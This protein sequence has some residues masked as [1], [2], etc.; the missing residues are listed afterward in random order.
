[1]VLLV[2]SFMACKKS[3]Q[4][5]GPDYI[6]IL[7]DDAS[8]KHYVA[9][10][11]LNSTR[12]KLQTASSLN[13]NLHRELISELNMAK[14]EVSLSLILN[15]YNLRLDAF[16][17]YLEYRIESHIKMRKNFPELNQ[18]QGDSESE[19]Y[20][21]AYKSVANNFLQKVKL[22]AENVS[23]ITN[24]L[25]VKNV[26]NQPNSQIQ[27]QSISNS[28]LTV[29]NEA[30]VMQE[31]ELN[32]DQMV[33][34]M[35]NIIVDHIQSTDITF[36]EFFLCLH[37]AAIGT[38]GEIK[39]IFDAAQAASTAAVIQEM[40]AVGAKWILKNI[41]WIGAAIL[42]FNFSACLYMVA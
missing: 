17:Q 20:E 5:S 34:L 15:K 1:M 14:N 33:E 39:K 40:V 10:D 30:E 32:E 29:S 3:D 4:T 41:G 42:I 37:A 19:I 35:A 36:G 26:I 24:K 23:V 27:Q 6:R 16:Q 25:P 8:F 7:E 2:G 18:M 28:V 22:K 11:I 13:K 38:F 9:N 31:L 12:F 21:K